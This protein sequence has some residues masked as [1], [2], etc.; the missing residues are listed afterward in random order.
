VFELIFEGI[1]EISTAGNGNVWIKG[2]NVSSDFTFKR[3][4]NDGLTYG[5]FTGILV[6]GKDV[7]ESNYIATE[8]SVVI[9]LKPA[10]LETLKTGLHT[11]TALFSDGNN[12]TI[13]FEIK[14]KTT[15][16]PTPTPTPV[17]KPPIPKTGV[18]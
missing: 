18:E 1:I 10:Y 11:L 16:T 14:D 6:D 5:K 8:G 17:P 2:S 3:K 9:D 13:N 7:D 12:V 15:P 4:T